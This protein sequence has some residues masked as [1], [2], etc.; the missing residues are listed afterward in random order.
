MLEGKPTL[1]ASPVYD[2]KKN[3]EDAV[4]L[5]EIKSKKPLIVVAHHG[6][7]PVSPPLKITKVEGTKIV[8]LDG[9]PAFKAWEQYAKENSE[10]MGLPL[11]MGLLLL[12]TLGF[13]T[14][15]GYKL[16]GI[17]GKEDTGAVQ[18]ISTPYEGMICNIM[19]ATKESLTEAARKTAEMALQAADETPI[20]GALVFDCVSH[21]MVLKENY[22]A[23]LNEIRSV[24]KVPVIG[25]QTLGE[26]A[27]ETGQISGYHDSATV[28]LLIPA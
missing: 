24:L 17:V 1:S 28:I 13:R 5:G 2:G 15:E 4:L 9:Q 18:I 25:F 11:E 21:S 20:A 14:K 19:G 10:A 27:V 6:Y 3:S 7:Y 8:E 16:K 26:Y 23:S 12:N 22:E